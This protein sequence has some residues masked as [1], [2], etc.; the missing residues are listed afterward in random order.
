MK[1]IMIALAVLICG[2]GAA[3]ATQA[4]EVRVTL[5][6]VEARG[7][8]IL[9]SLQTEAQ[10]MRAE[11]AYGQVVAV[12]PGA[13]TL[14]FADVAPGEYALSVLHDENGDQ[15]MQN[16]PNGMPA[17]GFALSNGAMLMGPPSWAVNKFTVGAAPVRLNERMTYMA[18]AAP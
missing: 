17:E 5:T 7:G 11:G 2:V 9:A 10:F 3:S 12:T 14:V 8:M 4:R 1:Q 15:R 13:V 18:P 6:G 16:Q